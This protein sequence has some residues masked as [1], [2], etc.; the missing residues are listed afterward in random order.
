MLVD[1]GAQYLDAGGIVQDDDLDT[2]FAKPVVATVK[3]HGFTYYYR[4]DVELAH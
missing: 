2:E 1:E 4:A 3:V